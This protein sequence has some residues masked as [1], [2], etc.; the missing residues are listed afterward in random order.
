MTRSFKHTA[1]IGNGGNSE[2]KDKKEYNRSLRHEIKIAIR[3]GE[4][5]NMPEY[6]LDG[7]HSNIWDWQK[8]GKHYFNAKKYPELMLR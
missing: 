8:D 7:N 3:K 1:I 2:K 6:K 4:L 5:M